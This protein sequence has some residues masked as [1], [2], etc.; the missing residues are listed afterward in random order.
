MIKNITLSIIVSLLLNNL[1]IVR[2]LDAYGTVLPVIESTVFQAISLVSLP[3][4]IMNNII[5]ATPLFPEYGKPSKDQG[6]KN[7]RE[8]RDNLI[9][10]T[11]N[12]EK[13]TNLQAAVN[14]FAACA[15]MIRLDDNAPGK[16]PPKVFYMMDPVHRSI[17][18]Y[19]VILSRSNLPWAMNWS[20]I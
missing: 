11:E 6:K 17:L 14:V 9:F 16:S 10:F 2:E 13:R 1:A 12:T 20:I 18:S 8:H 7:Q 5:S 4:A 3:V 15:D 19:L